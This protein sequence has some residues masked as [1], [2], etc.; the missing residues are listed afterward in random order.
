MVTRIG[1]AAGAVSGLVG[2]VVLDG[3]MWTLPTTAARGS[4]VAFATGAVHAASPAVGW[5]VYP[6]YGVVLGALF[7]WLLHGE[8]LDD[9]PAALWGAVYGIGWWVIAEV[10][11]I[12]ALFAAWPFSAAGL[13]RMRDVAVPLLIGHV[14]Y[15]AVLGL[16]WST[17]THR[18]VKPRRNVAEPARRAA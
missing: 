2:G 18:I 8:Q 16:M 1:I 4:M 13:A 7:G 12:P 15:G 5:I 17:L 9:L 3:L 11:L 6:A 14:V 10:I